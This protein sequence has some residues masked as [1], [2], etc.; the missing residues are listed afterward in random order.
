MSDS[1]RFFQIVF[2]SFCVFFLSWLFVYKTDINKLAIQSEDTLPAVFLPVAII[3][4]KTLYLNSYYNMMIER[5][6]HPDDKDQVRGLTPFYLKKIDNN[7]A[8]AF[9]IITPLISLPVYFLPL[10]LGISITW[11]N[12]ITLSK[13]SSSLIMALAEAFFIYF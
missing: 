1:K 13:I 4:E 8:S 12:L 2:I 10:K 6:P 5:Y 11:E 3:K 9:T 7:Y